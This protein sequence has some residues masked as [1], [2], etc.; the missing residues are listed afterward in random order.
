M[1]RVMEVHG[2]FHRA[3][4]PRPVV[5]HCSC[6]VRKILIQ[7][8]CGMRQP[9]VQNI[10]VLRILFF[11]GAEWKLYTRRGIGRPPPPR[12]NKKAAEEQKHNYRSSRKSDWKLA[13][14][15]AVRAFSGLHRFLVALAAQCKPSYQRVW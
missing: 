15:L 12:Q 8:I 2:H 7:K 14:F 4:F 11:V 5:E 9:I 6:H 13:P 10:N 3:Y 1:E